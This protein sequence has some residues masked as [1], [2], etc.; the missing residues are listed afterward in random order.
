MLFL[1]GVHCS[2]NGAIF[3]FGGSLEAR[4]EE[5]VPRLSLVRLVRV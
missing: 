2:V 1:L 5:V 3:G 4:V